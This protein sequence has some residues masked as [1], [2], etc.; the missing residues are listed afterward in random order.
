MKCKTSSRPLVYKINHRFSSPVWSCALLKF[1]GQDYIRTITHIQ[2]FTMMTIYCV[3]GMEISTILI[4][5][6]F[7]RYFKEKL[8]S[9][10]VMQRFLPFC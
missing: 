9:L 7:L 1:Q 3:F 5:I 2:L 4:T 6:L 10:R 8:L